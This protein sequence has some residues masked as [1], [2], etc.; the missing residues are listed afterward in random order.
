[1]R[2]VRRARIPKTID[3]ELQFGGHDMKDTLT[4]GAIVLAMLVASEPGFARGG[5]A[6]IMNSPG[7]QRRLQ[8][9]RQQL[10]QPDLQSPSRAVRHKPRH[11]H[12]H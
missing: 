1:V 2:I 12:R 5:A 4:L 10:A 7:Y 3:G 6:S 9:S 8:E 11:R